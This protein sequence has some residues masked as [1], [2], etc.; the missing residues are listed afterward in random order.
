MP[1]HMLERGNHADRRPGAL[2][3]DGVA[4]VGRGRAHHQAWR[5]WS[6]RR[7]PS[8]RAA[9]PRA[10]APITW[11]GAPVTQANKGGHFAFQG[12]VPADCV[13]RLEDGVPADAI[14][15]AL[16][17]C[18]PVPPVEFPAPVPQT[19]QTQCWD[20]GHLVTQRSERRAGWSR[21]GGR[22]LADP[23]FY[24]QREWHGAPTT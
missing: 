21:A 20:P 24:R 8:S 9:R 18:T 11:E 6:K 2:D 5:R 17:N 16:A 13:G 4:R 3:A 14:D 12:R 19:G 22:C 15:V 23:A 1:T 7:R 10:G